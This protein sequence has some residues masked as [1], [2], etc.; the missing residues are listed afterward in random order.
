MKINLS[1]V[2]FKKEKII[3]NKASEYNKANDSN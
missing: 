3:A 1:E 2:Q